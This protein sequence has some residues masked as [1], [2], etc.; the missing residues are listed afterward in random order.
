MLSSEAIVNLITA[1]G[2]GIGREEFNADKLRYHKIIIMTD[3]DVDGAHI[4]TLILTF[5]YRQ[6]PELIERG[7]IFIAQAPLYKVTKGKSSQ[8][9]KDERA[10]EDYL[11]DSLLD[12]A[13]LRAGSE[14]RAG[15][16]LRRV[17]TSKETAAEFRK[18]GIGL[19]LDTPADAARYFATETEKWNGVIRSANIQLD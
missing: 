15:A 11:I 12:G 7:H 8:Y 9:L 1:L 18:M 13:V 17:L 3:A 14:D 6:M 4:R 5:F 10:L 16:D 2:T 19:V